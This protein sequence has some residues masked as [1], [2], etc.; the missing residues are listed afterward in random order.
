MKTIFKNLWNRRRHNAWLFIELILVTVLCWVFADPVV[1]SFSDT[2]MPM[3][4]DVDRLAVVKI[5]SLPSDAP[6][7]NAEADTSERKIHA[8]K[9]IMS[10]VRAYPGVERA[11]NLF[12]NAMIG[13]NSIMGGYFATGNDARDT[14]AKSHRA[15]RYVPGED[16]FET[17]GIKASDGSVS[18]EDI[19]NMSPGTDVVIS[20]QLG[21]VYW[22]GENAMGKRVVANRWQIKSEGADTIWGTVRGVVEGVRWHSM[23]RAYAVEF[24]RDRGIDDLSPEN[25]GRIKELNVVLRMRE[26]VDMD[27]FL[28]EFR[29]WGNTNLRIDNY[30]MQS[31][32]SYADIIYDTEESYGVHSERN[33]QML[34]AV[35]FMLNLVLGTV[36]SFWLQ[37][38]KRVGEIGVRRAYGARRGHIVGMLMG[39]GAV[40]ATLSVFTGLLLYLQWAIRHGLNIGFS[41]NQSLNIVDN[42]VSHFGEHFLII[43]AI[44]YVIILLCVLAGTIIPALS[45]TRVNVTDALRD[46]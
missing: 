46:E 1:V 16:F 40:L 3:G 18:I 12:D 39:E 30:F 14:V 43:S 37:T 6:G 33:L 28:Q 7:Y 27:D 45:A 9:A 11:T 32:K 20:R 42:W 8:V 4:F 10:K 22:P 23:D 34:L 41:N 44:V 38:R 13:D 24:R 25:Y 26:G 31:A 36:G 21:E 5:N 2:S 17:Y 15:L 35:F 19:S 29:Q